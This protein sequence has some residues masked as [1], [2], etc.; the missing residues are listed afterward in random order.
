MFTFVTCKKGLELAFRPRFRDY[1]YFKLKNQETQRE[2][3]YA[4]GRY[5]QNT[6]ITNK[7]TE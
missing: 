5:V 2:C 4:L 6:Q 1:N 7:N 3:S